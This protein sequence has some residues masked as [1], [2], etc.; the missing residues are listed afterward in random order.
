MLT[1][2]RGTVETS[3]MK[4]LLW[5]ESDIAKLGLIF[6]NRFCFTLA[7]TFFKT[8]GIREPLQ[9]K[10]SLYYRICHADS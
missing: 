6:K 1:P 9:L 5:F 2:S 10:F 8:A 4:K 7:V 3:R